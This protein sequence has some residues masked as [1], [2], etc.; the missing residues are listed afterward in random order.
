MYRIKDSCIISTKIKGRFSKT[1]VGID[2]SGSSIDAADYAINVN[3]DIIQC[4]SHSHTITPSN[5]P[6]TDVLIKPVE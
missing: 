1:L 5:A 3:R 4:I 6:V 2:G